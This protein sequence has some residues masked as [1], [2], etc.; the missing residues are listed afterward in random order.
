MVLDSLMSLNT[1]TVVMARDLTKQERATLQNKGKR[2]RS[3]KIAVDAVAFIVNNQNSCSKLT[4]KEI[5]DILTGRT[6]NW[7]DLEPSNLGEISIIFDDKGSSLVT[8]LRDSLLNGESLGAN[9]YAQGSPQKVFETVRDNPNAIGVIGVSWLTSDLGSAD[10]N[11]EQA[12]PA[13]AAKDSSFAKEMLNDKP[14]EGSALTQKVKSLYIY[15]EKEGKAFR[16]YQQNI[17]DG[18][19][20]LFRQI[21]MITTGVSGSLESGFYAFVTGD[22]G[23]KIILKTGILPARVNIQ[24][25]ELGSNE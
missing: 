22:I 1:R 24:M 16:P 12:T 5:A 18:T 3:S 9:V 13:Q 2:V 17:F 6:A 23:Q 20:P 8:Y 4:L 11:P 10:Y 14:V 7:N 25:V 15:N 19:Y 21:Y